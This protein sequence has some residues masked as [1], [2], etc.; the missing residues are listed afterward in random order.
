MDIR[1]ALCPCRAGQDVLAP[2]DDNP[3]RS[4]G[5]GVSRGGSG[6]AP[7]GVGCHWGSGC[8][9]GAGVAPELEDL[10]ELLFHK[11]DLASLRSPARAVIPSLR[12]VFHTSRLTS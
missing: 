1:L 12:A 11:A 2:A 5:V 9:V 10:P 6:A 4:R 8:G 3:Q 7:R